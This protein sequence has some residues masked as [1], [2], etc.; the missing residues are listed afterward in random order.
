ML[1]FV[2]A[3]IVEQEIRKANQE[4]EARQIIERLRDL[5]TPKQRELF[6]SIERFF[7]VL[8][9][10]RSGKSVALTA[11]ILKIL[12]EAPGRKVLVIAQTRKYALDNYGPTVANGLQGLAD[13]CGISYEFDN[14]KLIMT[15]SNGS[16]VRLG[17]CDNSKEIGKLRGDP[18]EADLTIIDE[19]AN[20]PTHLLTLL[21]KD[22]VNPGL[23]TRRGRLCLAGTPGYVPV[24]VFYE[25]TCEDATDSAGQPT[26]ALYSNRGERPDARWT[27]FAW[28]LADNTAQPHQWEE[29]QRMRITMGMTE[30][31]PVWVREYLGRW[32]QSY[33]KLVYAYAQEAKTAGKVSWPGA[34]PVDFWTMHDSSREDWLVTLTMDFGHNSAILLSAHHKVLRQGYQL[35]EWRQTGAPLDEMIDVTHALI[36]QWTFPDAMVAD[37]AAKQ[38]ITTI[39]NRTGWPIQIAD[40]ANKLDSIRGT[41]TEFKLGR[42][43]VLEGSLLATELFNLAWKDDARKTEDTNNVNKFN[44]LG[45]CLLYTTRYVTSVLGDTSFVAT[46]KEK[47]R[48]TEEELEEQRLRNAFGSAGNEAKG[49]WTDLDKRFN[50]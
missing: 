27:L 31:D 20:I 11:L 30:D 49:L 5:L 4:Q 35:A 14:Q 18:A 45:D 9:P 38:S 10:R 6:D 33:D 50:Y 19:T 44:H 17:G 22:V 28:N 21:M 1:D 48:L 2:I 26:C 46:V 8:C 25:A 23:L 40:K 16:I 3:V 37:G 39:V 43:K 12:V 47:A 29:A 36:K 13:K 15:L 34:E 42:Y 24:G 41:N 7:S 32:V